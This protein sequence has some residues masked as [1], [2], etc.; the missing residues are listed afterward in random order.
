MQEMMKNMINDWMKN[1]NLGLCTNAVTDLWDTN[2]CFETMSGC[3]EQTRIGF[4]WILSLMKQV[5]QVQTD[6]PSLNMF[7]PMC[8]G[9]GDVNQFIEANMRVMGWVPLEAHR[10]LEAKSQELEKDHHALE[11]DAA[12]HKS[13]ITE[14]QSTVA[15]LDR[16]KSDSEKT[17]KAQKAELSEKKQQIDEL[18]KTIDGQN[19]K[20]AGSEKTLKA[21]KAKFAEQKKVVTKITRELT[22]EKKRADKNKKELSDVKKLVKELKGDLA[23]KEKR[24]EAKQ[25][26]KK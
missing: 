13:R 18:N 2:K 15:K 16:N 25:A 19:K 10:L 6:L 9:F 1:Y 21:Q 4:E 17:L 3:F 24:L 23:A 26:S 12:D 8:A 5:P 22:A 20:L 11:T 14:L 7:Q